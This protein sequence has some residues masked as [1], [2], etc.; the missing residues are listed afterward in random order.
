LHTQQFN[1][2][3]PILYFQACS[4]RN[5]EIAEIQS[6]EDND[7]AEQLILLQVLQR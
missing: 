7:A 3:I 6:Q 2:K 1:N 4:D 5:F